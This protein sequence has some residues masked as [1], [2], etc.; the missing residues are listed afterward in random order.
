VSRF[1]WGLFDSSRRRL[2]ITGGP[3]VNLKRTVMLLLLLLGVV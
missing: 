3:G 1:G 2:M